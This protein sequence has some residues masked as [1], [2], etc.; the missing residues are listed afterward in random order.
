MKSKAPDKLFVLG[1]GVKRLLR[2]GLPASAVH[3]R[4]SLAQALAEASPSALWM[5]AKPGATEE[6]LH[7]ALRLPSRPHAG[8]SAG[9]GR[10]SPPPPPTDPDLPD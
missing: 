6:L 9:S 4:R 5:A 3:G 1:P 2:F 8:K 10:E 7:E